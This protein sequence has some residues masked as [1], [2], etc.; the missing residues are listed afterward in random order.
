MEIKICFISGTRCSQPLD[1]T[2]EKKFR[3]LKALGELFVI[4]FSQD[5]RPRGFTEHARFYLLAKLPLPVLRYA[6][7]LM[8]GLPLV[9]W[10]IV[11]HGVQILVAQSPYEGF[12]AAWAKRIAGWLGYKVVLAVESHGDFEE[13]LF[14][15]RRI[16]LPEL[17]QPLMR[18]AAHFALTHADSLRV[19]SDATR[20]Q[21]E[22]W[23]PGRSMIQFPTWTD[24]EVFLKVDLSERGPLAQEILYTGALIPR[25][26]V[27][28]L[29]N[30]FAHV[31]KDF[32]QAGLIIVGHAEDKAYAA[33]LKEQV[34]RLGL[35]GRVQFVGMMP[36][37]ELAARMRR[38]C[39]FVLPSV[40]EGL[41]RVVVEAM[42]TGTP[43][44]GSDVGGIPDMV[45][46][47]VTGFLVP[48]GDERVLTSKIRWVL[49]YPDKAR[50]MGHHARA[51]AERFF[52]TQ[53]YVDGYRQTFDLARA[54]L[55]EDSEHAPSTL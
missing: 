17:Y 21:L 55:A 18:Y 31:A 4:G 11:R 8:M 48:P 3:A 28:H 12:V 46:D 39:V 41:G 52:S 13:S 38:A 29:I 24:I 1:A 34:K 26:G 16:L 9:L 44:I 32:L 49:E 6:E 47:G 33:E 35:D 51:F 53:G 40:S 5:L 19:I 27:H 25:K 7:T 23:V 43:V 10:L 15:Q 2:S 14:M 45:K 22:R 54:L 37:A 42:A 20:H 36:Q 30:A 50:E